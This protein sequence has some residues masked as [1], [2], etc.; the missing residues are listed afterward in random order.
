MSRDQITVTT[1]MAMNT[2]SV[3]NRTVEVG[4]LATVLETMKPMVT[5]PN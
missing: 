3:M 5:R 4:V 2:E 1:M